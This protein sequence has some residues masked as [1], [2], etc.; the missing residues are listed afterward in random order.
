[1]KSAQ[2][3]VSV[4]LLCLIVIL[5]FGAIAILGVNVN[6]I[7]GM[8]SNVP[9][10]L[11]YGQ[12]GVL[13][14]EYLIIEA[15]T[16]GRTD[17]IRMV[18]NEGAVTDN[19]VEVGTDVVVEIGAGNPYSVMA[20]TPGTTIQYVKSNALFSSKVYEK[21]HYF[22]LYSTW[23]T[24]VPYSVDMWFDGVQQPTV[25]AIQSYDSPRDVPLF[26]SAGMPAWVVQNGI[27]S[28]GLNIPSGS[29]VVVV[30]PLNSPHVFDK[31]DFKSAVDAYN[32]YAAS[33]LQTYSWQY[34]WTWMKD[35]GYLQVEPD[36]STHGMPSYDYKNELYDGVYIWPET[37]TVHYPVGGYGSDIAIYLPESVVTK[38]TIEVGMSK[39]IVEGAVLD[40]VTYNES[41][42][43][44]L[45]VSVKNIGGAGNIRVTAGSSGF[46]VT[47]YGDNSPY[48]P[49]GGSAVVVFDVVARDV[50]SPQSEKIYIL[51]DGAAPL[52]GDDRASVVA[53]VNDV[54]DIEPPEGWLS[55]WI[56]FLFGD[57]AVGDMF[58]GVLDVFGD[59]DQGGFEAMFGDLAAMAA[60]V[61]VGLFG[62]VIVLLALMYGPAIATFLGAV[63]RV[64]GF[65][66][67]GKSRR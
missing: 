54:P 47:P 29:Y 43:G 48:I 36:I 49:A 12:A 21:A 28:M 65:L 6:S 35:H 52:G 16:S 26:S 20:L 45:T 22:D 46:T 40:P 66:N 7:T 30:D 41:D 23:K 60:T 62:L 19:G 37:V 38:A 33:N 63:R 59:I 25:S 2:G 51:C 44:T 34:A 27:T 61:L 32:G 3:R 1:M 55:E 31:T 18:V 56:S 39:A 4:L 64:F 5:S 57:G 9:M 24:S 53:T 50:S 8:S 14:D 13:S 15:T 17:T 11:N 42:R 58:E 67:F 10:T